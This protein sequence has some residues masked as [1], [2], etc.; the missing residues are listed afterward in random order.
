MPALKISKKYN[1]KLIYDIYDYYVDSHNVP[2]IIKDVL[3]KL[4]IKIINNADTTIICGEW[5]KEQIKKAKPR[6]LVIIHNSPNIDYNAINGRTGIIKSDSD[7]VKIAYVGILQEGRLLKEVADAISENSDLELHVG[8]FGKFQDYFEDLSKKYENIYFY[9]TMKYDD[10]LK[11]ESECDIL[12][13]TYNPIVKNHKFSAPN[14]V[15][16][17]MALKKPIIVCKNTGIDRFVL[18]NNLGLAIEYNSL[19]F[20]KTVKSIKK[21][22]KIDSLDMFNKKYSWNQMEKIIDSIYR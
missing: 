6:N 10:V 18:K 12:F 22:S 1:K 4:E 20:I 13:A 11:L 3:E 17:A 7:R 8:G 2:S 19:D 9:G 21:H 5:R 15:Y 14:K 16:E